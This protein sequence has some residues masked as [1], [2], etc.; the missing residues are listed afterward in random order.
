MLKK[1]LFIILGFMIFS[2]LMGG[3]FGK[4]TTTSTGSQSVTV[5]P[6]EN[7]L[8]T[9][10]NKTGCFGF[11]DKMASDGSVIND[12]TNKAATDSDLA[13]AFKD[14]GDEF[15]ADATYTT[16]EIQT[17]LATSGQAFKQ[18]R[19]SLLAG[20]TT[21]LLANL[22]TGTNATDRLKTLCAS[23]GK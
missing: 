8:N 16:G 19:V 2:G 22:T 6:A 5:K 9:A 11:R 21:T 4:K 14:L 13:T 15:T 17:Q 12:W 10:D 3:F 1:T 23:I 20:D 7:L 18:A